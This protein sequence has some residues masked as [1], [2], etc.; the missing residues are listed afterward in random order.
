MFPVVSVAEESQSAPQQP[1]IRKHVQSIFW[2]TVS[3]ALKGFVAGTRSLEKVG[4]VVLIP[5]RIVVRLVFSLF[6]VNLYKGYLVVKKPIAKSLRPAKSRL[7]FP[8][9][10]RYFMHGLLIVITL[11]VSTNSLR[12]REIRQEELQH[13]SILTGLL[14]VDSETEIT[15][16]SDSRGATT[17]QKH[18]AGIGGVSPLDIGSTTNDFDTATTQDNSS[19]IK[20]DL[21]GTD[22]GSRPREDVAFH[23]V[24]GGETISTIAEQYHISVATILW[25][26]NLTDHDFIKPGQKLTILPV[27]GISHRVQSGETVA[28]IAKKFSANTDQIVEFNK[29]ASADAVSQG[30]ILIVPSG[31]PPAP[32]TPAPTSRLAALENPV[33]AQS[34]QDETP[35]PATAVPGAGFLWPT[36]SHKI[37]QYYNPFR[38]P[39]VDIDNAKLTSPIFASE[40]GRVTA[41][42]WSGGYG[43]HVELNHGNGTTTIYG[44]AS[45]VLVKTGDYVQRGQTIAI[46]GCTGRCTGE[47]LHFEIRI[48][49]RRVNPLS[50]L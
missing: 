21:T 42:G 45:R 36:D 13:P 50:Y 18:Y 28:S 8:F 14:K 35:P 1:P 7:L 29:L 37:N 22:I 20:P 41:A 30:D 32:P 38:H 39:G 2:H 10:T 19:L 11:F 25:E 27:T 47:H 16:T 31:T 15:E 33:P 26:N 48:G 5:F 49:G 43:L 6:L 9:A 4:G 12:A 17:T 23:V 44:H 24:E 46:Q 34:S 40:S 3:R